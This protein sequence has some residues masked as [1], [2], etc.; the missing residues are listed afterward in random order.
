MSIAVSCSSLRLRRV[1]FFACMTFIYI[2]D[3][4]VHWANRFTLV[5]VSS[6]RTVRK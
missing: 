3:A 4:E 2:F 1:G 5:L 6:S